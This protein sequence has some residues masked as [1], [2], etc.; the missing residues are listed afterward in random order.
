[1]ER[2][3]SW[4][5][6]LSTYVPAMVLALG[7][8]IALP[9]VPLLAKSFDV[10]FGLAS[11]VVTAFLAG[12]LC[13]SLPTGYLLDRFGRKKVLL[14][15]PILTAVA[16][17]LVAGAQSFPQLLVLRFFDGWAAQMWLIARVTAIADRASYAQRGRQVSWMYG[18]DNVGQLAGPI[19]G[20]IVATAWGLRMP[21][22]IYGLL[23]LAAVSPSFWLIKDTTPAREPAAQELGGVRARVRLMQSWIAPF[24]VLF[25]MVFL[26]AI[27]RTPLFSGTIHLYAAYAY[28]LT[29]ATIGILA[30]AASGISLPIGFVTGYLMDRFGR[31]ATMV[32]GF[33][34]LGLSLLLL[35]GTAFLNMS[36]TW[37]VGA[38]V[39]LSVTQS[40]TGGSMQT[41]GTDVAPKE[42]RGT[43]LGVW[44]FISQIGQVASPV[45]FAVLADALGYGAGFVLLAA[46]AL[47]VGL[48]LVVKVE[49]PSQQSAPA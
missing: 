8:A 25:V 16:A 5:A 31:K 13:S 46:S 37:Y 49:E 10:G 43:F 2:A 9:S 1:M 27:A 14:A 21:F 19:V 30:T 12:G 20:G 24:G 18:M 23:A 3:W 44:R 7:N 38:F 45:G 15:G 26:V 28:N 6:L 35:A 33:W 22:V 17:F 40:I 34:G 4:N 36:F 29:P 32:P 48:L 11:M 42:A 39:V 41:L 47:I